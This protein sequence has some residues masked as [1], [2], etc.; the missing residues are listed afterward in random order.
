MKLNNNL[1]NNLLPNFLK[2]K[3]GQKTIV[4]SI[5]GIKNNSKIYKKIESKKTNNMTI[6]EHDKQSTTVEECEEKEAL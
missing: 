3:K 5:K 4:N 1:E 6:I 2:N